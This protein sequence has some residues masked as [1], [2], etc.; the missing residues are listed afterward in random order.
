MILYTTSAK[1]R[2][3]MAKYMPLARIDTKPMKKA[4]MAVQNPARM[5]PSHIEGK[6]NLA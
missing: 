1:A 2:V 6:R 4:R 5:S 3:R